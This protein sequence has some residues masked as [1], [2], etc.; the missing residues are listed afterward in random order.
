MQM[1]DVGMR[2]RYEQAW[3]TPAG[4]QMSS[5]EGLQEAARQ[6]SVGLVMVV[7]PL[8]TS[9]SLFRGLTNGEVHGQDCAATLS[10]ASNQSFS[11]SFNSWTALK[12]EGV[13]GVRPPL[14][15]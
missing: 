5:L 11:Q 1:K 2:Q 3:R 7:L 12:S 10:Q 13:S 9:V 6:R 4:R 8:H 14:C 15:W